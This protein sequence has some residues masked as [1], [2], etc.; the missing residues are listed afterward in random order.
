M[1]HRN[2]TR[3]IP[4]P[5]A[6]K[7]ATVPGGDPRPTYHEL[8]HIAADLVDAMV[9]LRLADAFVIRGL[10]GRELEDFLPSE[11]NVL[12]VEES[13]AELEHLAERVNLY[14]RNRSIVDRDRRSNQG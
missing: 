11:L 8:R 2:L 10:D 13:L 3:P 5:Q 12:R 7:S 1:D 9:A 14:L 6:A 4:G